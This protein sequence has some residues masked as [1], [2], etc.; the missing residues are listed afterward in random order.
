[1]TKQLRILLI[2]DDEPDCIAFKNYVET[3]D[4]IIL[5]ACTANAM[6]AIEIIKKDCPDAIIIDLEL[7]NGGGNGLQFLSELN[8]LHLR[9]HPYLLVTTNNSSRRTHQMARSLGADFILVKYQEDYSAQYVID[10]IRLMTNV[11]QS[12]GDFSQDSSIDLSS[13]L[14]SPSAA[15]TNEHRIIAFIREEL[16]L[17]GISP[18]AVGYQYL[19]DAIYLKSQNYDTNF[20]SILGPRYRKSDASIERSMQYAINRAWRVSDPDDLLTY[21]TARIRSD[22]GVPTI[23]EFVY[24]YATKVRTKFKI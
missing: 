15:S 23:M 24:F 6:S 22:R 18:K 19:T 3:L 21:Y 11:A 2:E 13:T 17:V 4:D 5:T 12:H 20:F 8:K 9:D 7:H 16:N 14:F 10:F 1:M